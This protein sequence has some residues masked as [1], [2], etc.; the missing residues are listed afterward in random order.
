M[1]LMNYESSNHHSYT[2][3]IQQ[4]EYPSKRSLFAQLLFIQFF[5]IPI[6]LNHSN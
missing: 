6:L 3:L 1:N 4:R 5:L 2:Q